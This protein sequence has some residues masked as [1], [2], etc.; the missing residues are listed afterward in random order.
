[1]NKIFTVAVIG[2]GN[3]GHN[4]GELMTQMP[5]KYKVVSVC[6][7]DKVV[8]DGAQAEWG[9][10]PENLFKDEKE[11][12]SKKRADVLVIA[13]QDRQHVAMCIRALELGYDILMEKPISP[14]INEIKQLLE[15]SR[16]YDRKIVVCHVLRYA[17]AYLKIKEILD[18]GEIGKLIHIESIENVTWWH[19]AHSFVR[20]NWRRDDE[21]SPMILQKCCHD[22]DILQYLADS[23]CDTVYSVG[24]TAFFNK[25]NQPEGAADRCQDCKYKLSCP[26]SAEYCYVQRWKEQGALPKDW[27]FSVVCNADVL[28]EQAIRTAYESNQYGRCVFACDNNVVDNQQVLLSFKNGISVSHTMSA[29]TNKMGRVIVLHG[30][31]GEVKLDELKD[32]ITVSIYKKDEEVLSIKN[33]INKADSMG[34]GGGDALLIEDLYDIVSGKK[35]ASTAIEKSIESH[36]MAFAAEQS[37]LENKIIKLHENE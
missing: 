29:F 24:R 14:D 3:R 5:D 16:K 20:G 28:T 35:E 33:L 27:P 12:L 6:D 34:H 26:F 23:K 18:S 25:Q 36:L 9:I 19:Q 31:L 17:P 8:R 10:L 7:I 37:R 1:M 22:M 30:T 15:T 2:C 13:T 4:Y 21:T 11:F 32:T